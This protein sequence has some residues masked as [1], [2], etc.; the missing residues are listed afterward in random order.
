MD[1]KVQLCEFCVVQS[2]CTIADP[3]AIEGA[4]ISRHLFELFRMIGDGFPS[5]GLAKPICSEV[6]VIVIRPN[7][8]IDLF[9]VMLVPLLGLS[10][11]SR[12]ALMQNRISRG[13]SRCYDALVLVIYYI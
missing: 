7:N 4:R 3:P 2:I 12:H 8:R 13:I 9:S 5:D 10:V 1:L 6:N 11:G